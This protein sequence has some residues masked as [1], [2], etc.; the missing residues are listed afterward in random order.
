[1][2]WAFGREELLPAVTR[3][4]VKDVLGFYP[5]VA[6]DCTTKFV[7]VERHEN[8][9]NRIAGALLRARVSS[10]HARRTTSITGSPGLGTR[11]P[12]VRANG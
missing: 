9:T 8:A 4:T 12:T 5:M 2:L 7:F 6:I 10:S 3:K 11:G 1:M